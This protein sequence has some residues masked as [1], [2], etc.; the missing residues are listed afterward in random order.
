MAVC[1]WYFNFDLDYLRRV[2][3]SEPLHAKINPAHSDHG[4]HRI[5]SSYWLANFFLMKK[6]RQSAAL[7]WFGLR[8]VEVLHSQ[9]A[10]QGTIVVPPE[11][12][13]HGSAK[14]DRGLSTCK[15]WTE[16]AGGLEA[17]LH[18]AAHNLEVI[19]NI[20]HWN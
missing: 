10:I 11:F 2:Q 8:N 12:L 5:F 6:I 4:L 18:E 1:F 20:Q 19:S 3:S 15:P 7:F 9:A 16:Q 14:K 13:E 17:F